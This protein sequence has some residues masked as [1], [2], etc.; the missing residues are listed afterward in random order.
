MEKRDYYEVLNVSRNADINEIKGAYR[1][2]AMQYHPD[3][4]PNDSS[5]EE[6]FKEAAEAYEV[7]SDADKRSKYD[8]YGHQGL[9]G[10]DFRGYS[11]V[12][13][14]FSAF[15]DIFSGSGIFGDFFGSNRGS[16]R[17]RPTEI[18]GSDLKIRLMLTLEEI[19]TG[20]EK[21]VKLKKWISCEACYGTG[22]NEGSGLQ[23]CRTCGGHGEVRQVS[24][25]IFGQF[26]NIST[27]PEC[28]GTGKV[29]KNP[30]SVCSGEGRVM[31]EEKIQVNVPAGVEEG[32]Y[33]PIRG[34]GNQGKRGGSAG[35]LI[36][37][38]AEKE[39]KDFK[40]Q[41]SNVFHHTTISFTDAVLGAEIVVP[42]L[43][44]EEEVKVEPG[45]QPGT[46]II[47]KDRGIPHLNSSGKGDQVVFL[48]IFV[49]SNVNQ[50]ER[51]LLIELAD[52]E[53]FSPSKKSASKT[54][55]FFEKVKDVFF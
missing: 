52:S 21:T 8:R 12:D 2:L 5:A 25:S 38:I 37:I 42:T 29:I 49:P 7:L 10:T 35:D 17:R 27:C 15:G 3:R 4:N 46:T 9:R 48:N 47:L 26:V 41:G 6:K 43:Y 19:A 53:N 14:I 44:G 31:S 30:C 34:K 45:S 13:D 40:R 11:N 55:D 1:K 50:K 54:K 22:A 51:L 16:S 39:H 24:R 23:N 18:R 20:A 28:N 32:N 36:V 33:I